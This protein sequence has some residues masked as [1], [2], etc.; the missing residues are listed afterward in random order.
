MASLTRVYTTDLWRF[1]L[2]IFFARIRGGR[3]SDARIP[4][5]N[6]DNEWVSARAVVCLRTV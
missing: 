1:V 6:D 5:Y 2:E 4:Y 3:E